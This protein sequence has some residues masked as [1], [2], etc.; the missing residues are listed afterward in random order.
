MLDPAMIP[1]QLVTDEERPTITI[2][3]PQRPA[4]HWILHFVGTIFLW[5]LGLLRTFIQRRLTRAEYARQL[6]CVIERLGGLWIK[7]GQLVSL[8][9][10]MF[11]E[12]VCYELSKLQYRAEGFPTSFAR[13]IIEESLGTR[14]EDHFDYFPDA[15]FATAS[16]G[17][18]YRAHLR[19]EDVWVAVKV[20]RP[21]LDEKFRRDLELIGWVVRLLERFTLLRFLRSDEALW[22]LTHIMNEELDYR[23][24]ASAMSRMKKTLK[25]HDIYVPEVFRKY[26]TPRVL[27]TEFIHAALMAD[28]IGM[29]LRSP[30]RLSRWLTENNIDPKLVARRLLL[31]IF[32]QLFEDNLYHGDLHPGNIIL[33]KD[34]R[35]AF[36]DMGTVGFTETEFLERL[37]IF[38]RALAMREFSNAADMMLLLSPS[39][40]SINT[41]E[42]KGKFIRIFRVWASRTFVRELPYHDKSMDS[43]LVELGRLMFS[44][45]LTAEWAF[46]RVR[47]VLSTLDSALIHLYPDVNYTRLIAAYFKA[48]ER[49]RLRKAVEQIAPR[50]V[51]GLLT[52]YDLQERMNEFLFHQ[53]AI[54]R[55]QAQV[56]E[57]TTS[58]FSYFFKLLF[59]QLAALEIIVGVVFF[60]TFLHQHHR[61]WVQPW[62]GQQID[63]LTQFLPFLDYQIWLVLLLLDLF[64]CLTAIKLSRRFAQ[65]ES[66][67]ANG[68]TLF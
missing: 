48:A 27:V 31:S 20:Q 57:G 54:V 10:D 33:L 65:R 8:R 11:S 46:L 49:R 68:Q 4:N 38:T 2:V 45:R 32:R 18:I 15:P 39:L 23:F 30:E 13:K 63:R 40:P 44:Y 14:I 64:F 6:R 50:T 25:R 42:M 12:E 17:Q 36:I 22:E 5:A 28:F 29:Y 9:V 55:R 43:V 51:N 56:F 19:H 58:K 16:I 35:V 62:M 53:S 3:E 61:N 7:A 66:R 67:A 24:E 37:R 26:T 34:S 41:E 1:T 52:A 21:Y 60:L 47:R 59:G